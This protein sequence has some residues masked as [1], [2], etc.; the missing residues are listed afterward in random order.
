MPYYLIE[1]PPRIRQFKERGTE[2]S[3]TF[4][5]HT[6]ENTPDW[7]GN[8]TG[9]ENIASFISNR[10]DYGSYHTIC[11][12]DSIVDLVPPWLQAYGDGT[13]SNP[14]AIH[15]SGATQAAKWNAAPQEWREEVATNMGVAAGRKAIWLKKYKGIDVPARRITKEQSD[16]RARGFITHAERDPERRT[17]PGKDFPWNFFWQGFND[18]V[19]PPA[20]TPN[21]TEALNADTPGERKK[22]LRRVMRHGDGRSAR[23]AERWLK[24]IARFEAIRERLATNRASLKDLEVK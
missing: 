18:T 14:Y 12:S 19:N 21:I 17:D 22:A 16:N 10:T 20:K 9:A 4:V 1:N 23:I 11:D 2:P 5:I 6:A 3:G 13:G 24:N 15:I 7:V 8:D